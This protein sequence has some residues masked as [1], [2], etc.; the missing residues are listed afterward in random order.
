[1]NLRFFWVCILSLGIVSTLFAQHTQLQYLSGK[2]KD[3]TVLWDFMV[4]D[5]MK[6]GIWS[7]IPVPSNWELQG[8]GK[9]NYGFN[10]EENKGK[11]IGYYAHSFRLD[12]AWKGRRIQLVFE[13]VMT[14]AEVRI[15]GKL[16]GDIH[17]GSF[18]VFKYDI[19]RLIKYGQTNKIEVKVAKHSANKS[20]NAAEREADYW[21]FGG[22]FRPVYLEALP[23]DHLARVSIDAKA[24]GSFATKVQVL[25]KADEIQVQL[26]DAANQ[27]V[28]KVLKA[29]VL[30]DSTWIK[31]DFTDV[32]LWS[33]EFPNRYK[34]QYTLWKNGKKIHEIDQKFGFRTVQVKERDGLYINGKKI[35]FKGVNRHSFHPESGRTTSAEISIHDV[36]L[37]K[38]MN[39]NAVRMAHYPP[40]GHF[41]EACD[42]LG[43]YVMN[44]LA[45]WHGHYDTTVGSK[46][47]Y[48]MMQVSDNHPSIFQRKRPVKGGCHFSFFK[49]QRAPDFLNGVETSLLLVI[50]T[51]NS[52]GTMIAIGINAI[53]LICTYYALI[54]KIP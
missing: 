40:D 5:G 3:D 19:S 34:A 4:S 35:K 15:N 2:G 11:E 30:A 32:K 49:K 16:A 27:P 22:I 10:K 1:M 39:M 9:Y 21:I 13:G 26:F 37:I 8:F 12:P 44:E 36:K 14:D 50:G 17:Q 20:V 24:D 33:A 28:G 7:K 43:L 52:I 51:Y 23:Q 45:G 6:A 46:L 38:E 25:G 29:A 47:L 53:V 54:L 18:Y 48:E 41:L 31:A 42:S